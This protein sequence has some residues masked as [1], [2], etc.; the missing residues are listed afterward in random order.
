MEIRI[1]WLLLFSRDRLTKSYFDDYL[2]PASKHLEC[3]IESRGILV[4]QLVC[5]WHKIVGDRSQV[6]YRIFLPYDGEKKKKAPS[7]AACS[8]W[9]LLI[10]SLAFF[11]FAEMLPISSTLTFM[12]RGQFVKKGAIFHRNHAW[13]EP[14]VASL[15]RWQHFQK[16][17]SVR[18]LISWKKKEFGER[19]PLG[20][21]LIL[22]RCWMEAGEHETE[23]KAKIFFFA[24][25][26]SERDTRSLAT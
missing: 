10:S 8:F 13:C 22:V 24:P 15:C 16:F 12:A 17:S 14:K 3:V 4:Q 6:K 18:Q 7:H 25:T 19:K 26:D 2:D 21:L 5:G 9:L 11:C 23:I 20:S 1:E